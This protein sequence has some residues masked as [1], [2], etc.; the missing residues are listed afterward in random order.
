MSVDTSHPIGFIPRHPAPSRYLRIRAHHKKDKKFHRVFLAQTLEG[1]GPLP[2]AERRR[3]TSTH[4]NGEA[5]GRAIWAVEFS[6]DG[7]YLAAAGQDRKVRVWATITTPEAR[8]AAMRDEPD[9][10]TEDQDIPDLKAPVFRPKPIQV[11]EGH[12][13][14]IL[15]LSWSK[16]CIE[17]L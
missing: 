5:T 11:F 2:K 15:D 6:K 13:G 8:E 12:E 4:I 7:R 16:V 3:S 1:T 17:K 14:S 9:A 10:S